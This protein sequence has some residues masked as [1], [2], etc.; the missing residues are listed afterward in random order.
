MNKIKEIRRDSSQ[1]VMI[2]TINQLV[3]EI[4][5]LNMVLEKQKVFIDTLAMPS[6]NESSPYV[7]A[8]RR[9]VETIKNVHKHPL[10]GSIQAKEAEEEWKEY[11]EETIPYKE[12]MH[13]DDTLKPGNK[14]VTVASFELLKNT[15]NLPYPT[16]G[17]ELTIRSVRLHHNH[18][19]AKKG[20]LLLEFEEIGDIL[21]ICNKTK[22]GKPNFIKIRK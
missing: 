9:I 5:R 15:Y 20:V 19:L 1:L 3:E 17:D 14:V 8:A 18:D 7:V 13:D 6:A 21:K 4:N 16:K 10:K 2:L 11:L 22:D 12:L